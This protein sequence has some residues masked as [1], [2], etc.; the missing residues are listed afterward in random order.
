[1]LPLGSPLS[2]KP[3]P[4][5]P[6]AREGALQLLFLHYKYTSPQRYLL[7]INQHNE[8]INILVRSNFERHQANKHLGNKSRAPPI[9]AGTVK[10]EILHSGRSGFK[11]N[12][13]AAPVS[14]RSGPMQ[15]Y[16][17]I[18]VKQLTAVRHTT[19][20][21]KRNGQEEHMSCALVRGSTAIC[22]FLDAAHSTASERSH[23]P[24]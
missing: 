23:H 21:Y 13:I 10:S 19:R 12:Y 5:V 20:R 11:P 7:Q 22:L 2:A 1:M 18:C 8:S 3:L 4:P 15:L 9:P 17:S 16:S 24:V 6:R 14:R